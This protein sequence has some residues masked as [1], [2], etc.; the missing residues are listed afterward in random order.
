[1]MSCE[2]PPCFGELFADL[3]DDQRD[4]IREYIANE[5]KHSIGESIRNIDISDIGIDIVP[6]D[7]DD[8]KLKIGFSTMLFV[9][10]SVIDRATARM[11][12]LIGG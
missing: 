11:K 6:H 4:E 10:S 9:P 8:A 1:M 12:K 2:R 7:R 3:S 5:M